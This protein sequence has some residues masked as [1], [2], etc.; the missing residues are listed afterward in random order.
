M[1]PRPRTDSL[2]EFQALPM[3]PLGR[4]FLRGTLGQ[5]KCHCPKSPAWRPRSILT[6]GTACPQCWAV[7]VW[8]DGLVSSLL[9]FLVLSAE[10]TEDACWAQGAVP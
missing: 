8:L 4:F 9:M 1:S 5:R 7:R 6:S 2:R 10:W 3:S